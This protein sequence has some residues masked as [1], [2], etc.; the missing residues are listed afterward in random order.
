MKFLHVLVFTATLSLLLAGCGGGDGDETSS[1]QTETNSTT[2]EE[3]QISTTPPQTGNSQAQ[4]ELAKQVITTQGCGSCHMIQSAGF[5]LSGQ[6]G[7]D[8][9]N[10]KA[11]NR[12]EE[13][14]RTQLTNPTEIPDSEVAEGYAGMQSVMPSYASLSEEEL[15]ALIA[16]LMNLEA[17]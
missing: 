3:P 17:E 12:S 11:R 14:L 15:N 5:E 10:Q 16:L 13:W 8:L 4:V 7:P 2:T 9:T 1:N 6:V